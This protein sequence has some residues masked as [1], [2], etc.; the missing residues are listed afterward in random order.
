MIVETKMEGYP[1]V[2]DLNKNPVTFPDLALNN[3]FA[4]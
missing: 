3:S 4:Q 2:I 1:L